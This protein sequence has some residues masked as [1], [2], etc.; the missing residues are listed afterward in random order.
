MEI[1]IIDEYDKNVKVYNDFKNKIEILLKELLVIN[2]LNYHNISSRVKNKESLNKKISTKDK[3]KNI[4]E[5][6]DIIGTRII[7]YFDDDVEKVVKI[8]EKEFEID[9]ENSVNKKENIETDKFGYISYHL[10]CKLKEPRN[11]LDEYKRYENIKFEIQIRSILQHAWAEIEHDLGYKSKSDIPKVI[12]RR[13]SRIAGLLETADEA[14]CDI[15]YKLTEYNQ[16]LDNK[17]TLMAEEINLDSI[18]IFTIK[19][20]LLKEINLEICHAGKWQ[21]LKDT[22][23]D[24]FS[25]VILGFELFEIKSINQLDKLISKYKN[26]I[27]E[28]SKEWLK[29]HTIPSIDKIP[30]NITYF[31]LFYVLSYLNDKI[32]QYL[33]LL[34][35]TSDQEDLNSRIIETCK[36]IGIKK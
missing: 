21:G 3:Y 20:D 9:K 14:F 33:E 18:Y 17:S 6:T 16:S 4:N 34:S 25:A 8:L 5:I 23:K 1:K 30:N 32:I 2:N 36:K 27:I 28:F 15:K 11:K 12:R 35:I 24:D 19:S 10:I 22:K 7:T 26:Y 31:Y 29:N 13:F